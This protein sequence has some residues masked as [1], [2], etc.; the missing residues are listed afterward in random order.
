MRDHTQT[1]VSVQKRRR[2]SIRTLIPAVIS[3]KQHTVN[4][5][6]I[7]IQNKNH[8]LHCA[9]IE[10]DTRQKLLSHTAEHWNEHER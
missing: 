6:L 7:N 3:L 9:S 2:T 8:E 10:I 1:D 5:W 4:T